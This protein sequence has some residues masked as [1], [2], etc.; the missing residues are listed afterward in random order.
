MREL[1]NAV[2]GQ[3]N[4]N[5]YLAKFESFDKQGVGLKPS[6]NWSALF[7]TG[8]WALYRK[9]Y[10]WFFIWWGLVS[11]SS[12]LEKSGSVVL[13]VLSVVVSTIVFAVYANSLYYNK[14]KEE[15]AEAQLNTS[16]ESKLFGYLKR[17]GGVHK[18]VIWVF[19]AIPIIGIGLAILLPMVAD[20]KYSLPTTSNT[21]KNSNNVNSSLPTVAANNEWT[22][23]PDSD[24]NSYIDLGSVRRDGNFATMRTLLQLTNTSS[25]HISQFDCISKTFSTL[26]MTAFRERMG[27][28]DVIYTTKGDTARSWAQIPSGESDA[29][30]MWKIAC[31][32][33]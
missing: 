30:T 18:W 13:S 9:M 26:T 14:V 19:G 22:L 31:E 20:K 2:I 17:K 33:K 15:I 5:Y 16:D 32:K 7:A 21:L 24:G 3:N 8:V 6:W 23:L 28:G 1:Y 25:I 27:K 4:K 10:G 11:L 12:I 29:Y